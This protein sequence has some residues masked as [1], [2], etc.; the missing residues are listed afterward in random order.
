MRGAG[1]EYAGGAATGSPTVEYIYGPRGVLL[2]TIQGG[3]PT[4]HLRDHLSV[5]VSA[6]PT[7]SKIGEQGHY[8]YG[9]TWYASGATTKWQFTSYERDSETGNDY[10]IARFYINRFGRFYSPDPASGS[11][12]NPQSVNLFTYVV[13]DP[14]DYTDPDGTLMLQTGG[15]CFGSWEGTPPFFPG[16]GFPW[17]IWWPG[18]A[19]G[20]ESRPRFPLFLIVG[21]IRALEG[22][23]I[24][25]SL[26]DITCDQPGEKIGESQCRDVQSAGSALRLCGYVRL[27]GLFSPGVTVVPIAS[28]ASACKVPISKVKCPIPPKDIQIFARLSFFG[29]IAKVVRVNVQ[30][31]AFK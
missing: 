12:P 26:P 21:L 23:S 4:Y 15:A 27:C 3:T 14:I 30:S 10:A 1:H 31:A 18:G 8:P 9:E 20:T 24:G 22:V 6:G 29:A 13:D 17:P 25:A 5:R 16:G 7:G 11:P 2:A 19:G 28:M